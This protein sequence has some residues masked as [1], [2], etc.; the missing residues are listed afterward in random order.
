MVVDNAL[1]DWFDKDT[2]MDKLAFVS[3]TTTTMVVVVV[4]VVEVMKSSQSLVV[5]E[6]CNENDVVGFDDDDNLMY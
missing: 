3:T 2:K 4:A 1:V 5:A 6:L